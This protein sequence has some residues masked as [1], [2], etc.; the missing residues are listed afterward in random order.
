MAAAG[1]RVHANGAGPALRGARELPAALPL[2]PR[3]HVGRV[4][5][6]PPGAALCSSGTAVRPP[7]A[8]PGVVGVSGSG[9]GPG[10]GPGGGQRAVSSAG[11]ARPPA[12]LCHA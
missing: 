3:L 9:G 6:S 4:T 12:A 11:P 2:S 1:A 10:A 7:P 8:A 5:R